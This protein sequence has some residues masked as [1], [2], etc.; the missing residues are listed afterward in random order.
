MPPNSVASLFRSKNPPPSDDLTSSQDPFLTPTPASPLPLPVSI[1]PSALR[2][3]AF[4]I[5]TKKH[6]LTLKSDA[7][8]CLADYLG[9]KLGSEWRVKGELVLDEIARAW[10]RTEG[11][12]LVNADGLKNVIKAV[13][14][15]HPAR[16]VSLARDLTVQED[17]SMEDSS[18][19]Q[20][21][22]LAAMVNSN[23][24]T[25]TPAALQG[26]VDPNRYFA[27]VDAFKQPKYIYH[28]ARRHYEASPT[29][30]ALIAP[31]SH[32]PQLWRER[33]DIIRQRLARN[34]AFQAPTFSGGR[35]K[36]SYYKIISIKNLLGR[37]GQEFMIYGMV[38]LGAEGRY[39]LED[40]DD[41]VL[42][43]LSETIPG[44][45]FF[46]PSMMV[47]VD[48]TYTNRGTFQ[49]LSLGHPPIEKRAV[50]M[51]NFGHVDFLGVGFE[52]EF[53]SHMIRAEHRFPNLKWVF[54]GESPLDNPQTL[55]S[56]AALF[57]YYEER[58]D[59][60]G[61]PQAIV[62]TGSFTSQPFHNTGQSR[63]YKSLWDSLAR[64]I[65]D[66]P[67]LCVQTHFIFIPGPNDPW[68]G[69]ASGG[70]ASSLPRGKI[71]EFF[72]GR[73]RRAVKSVTFATNPVRLSWF[74]Q[75]VVV[76][77]DDALARLRRNQ[78]RFPAVSK[79]AAPTGDIPM[80]EEHEH[81]EADVDLDACRNLIRTLLDQSH[82]SPLP[83][84]TRPIAWDLDHAL[85]LYP[86]PTALVL[87]DCSAPT[88]EVTYEGCPTFNPGSVSVDGGSARGVRRAQWVEWSPA[89]R[90]GV[91]REVEAR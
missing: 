40:G 13:D 48:G 30:A 8:Q 69:A 16:P 25:S 38:T 19:S 10:K 33:F 45:G 17:V 1:P 66:Y 4:R 22:R 6:N 79:T 27:V 36:D 61:V 81:E 44:P 23:A 88:W 57:T 74:T 7:L 28:A 14:V 89:V 73:V 32:L 3:I 15:P 59:T 56:L 77:R 82:L 83:L 20:P 53:E 58:A 43:E 64:L 35:D 47:L 71:S 70:G 26:D 62:L 75:E 65:S 5:F 9:P 90:K 54:A 60:N 91:R 24:P 50:S 29:P 18:T 84:S 34:D 86:M 2:P 78:V 51:Q 12:A 85:R 63:S 87:V 52:K 21:N 80:D 46:T 72:T 76:F 41:R 11:D 68:A 55:K 37:H 31:A 42:L 39:W 67:T 49:P